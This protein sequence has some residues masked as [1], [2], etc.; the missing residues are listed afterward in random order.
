MADEVALLLENVT[1]VVK[2]PDTDTAE[3]TTLEAGAHMAGAWVLVLLP[4]A[5]TLD[6]EAALTALELELLDAVVAA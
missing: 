3:L 6:S 2:E 5:A 1:V 4:V